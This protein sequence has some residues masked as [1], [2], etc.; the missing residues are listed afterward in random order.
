MAYRF[1][2]AVAVGVSVLG[3]SAA[4]QAQTEF[5]ISVNTGANHIRNITLTEFLSDL[6]TAT[7][8]ALVGELFDNG[9]LY[10]G[11]DVPR[12]VARGDVD[13]AVPVTVYLSP[14]VPDLAVLDLALFSGVPA[15]QFNQVV[16]GPLGQE[17]SR[18]IAETLEVEVPGNWMLLGSANTFGAADPITS[19]DDLAGQRI[20]IPGGAAILSHYQTLDADPVV[21]GFGDVPVALSQGTIDGILTTNETIRSAQL[22]EAGVTSGFLD[23]VQTLY[24]VPIVNQDFWSGLTEEQRTTFTDLWNDAM[25]AERAEAIRRQAEAQSINEENGISF[26]SPTA[27]EAA[28]AQ[29]ALLATVDAVAAELEI[30]DETLAVAREVSGQ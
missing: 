18:Q 19:Y 22:W 28:T 2:T 27:E 11:R 4:A 26:T 23:N 30:S 10:G 1:M 5:S 21:I 12:A 7:N 13:M 20:R 17:L 29:A 3:L 9:Q 8:G 6:E 24:Y 14:F 25:E 15:E 16:D